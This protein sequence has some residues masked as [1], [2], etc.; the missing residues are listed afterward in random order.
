MYNNTWRRQ[1]NEEMIKE[2]TF[3]FF[4]VTLLTVITE[5]DT[6][7]FQPG[8]GDEND[9]Y[10]FNGTP[11]EN[12]GDEG[13]LRIYSYP[14]DGHIRRGYL[15]FIEL[16]D[17]I[18]GPYN[19]G[20]AYLYLHGSLFGSSLDVVIQPCKSAFDES[21]ITWNNKPGAIEDVIIL[22]T[23]E[24]GEEFWD[25][26]VTEI[27]NAWVEEEYAHYGFIIKIADETSQGLV[28][29]AAGEYPETYYRPRLVI[30]Y[31]DTSTIAP[32]SMGYIKSVYR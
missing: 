9:A 27:V 25:V 20:L 5:A 6:L 26:N 1:Y 28:L 30:Q 13:Q 16:D 22:S 18:G 3:I 10:V 19:V 17:Y 15:Q 32:A 12:F 31:T 14:P 29:I 7:I 4:A 24:Y 11:D 23:F 8:D 21:T 2:C